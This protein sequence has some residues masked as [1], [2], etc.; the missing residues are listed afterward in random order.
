MR[1]IRW[2]I[3]TE[4]LPPI[5]DVVAKLLT[6]ATLV[7]AQG[8]WKGQVERSLIVEV[9]E[10]DA[11]LIRRVAEE[12]KTRGGQEAVLVTQEPLTQAVLV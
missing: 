5:R 12:I 6:G 11:D 2:R 3:Y 10:E 1:G 9:I 8:I 4:D 7:A